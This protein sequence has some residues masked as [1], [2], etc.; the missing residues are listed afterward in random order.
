MRWDRFD[1]ACVGVILAS[2]AALGLLLAF[3]PFA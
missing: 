1:L 3:Q 2:L